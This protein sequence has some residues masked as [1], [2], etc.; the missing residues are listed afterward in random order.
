MSLTR[1]KH[2]LEVITNIVVVLFVVLA[3]VV[4]AKNY[5]TSRN[6][7]TASAKI[8]VGSIFPNIPETNYGQS[9]KTLVIALN[10]YCHYCTQSIP[11]YQR[12]AEAQK[13]NNNSFQAVAVFL[14]KEADLVKQYVEEKKL[15][16]N[17]VPSVDFDKLNITSTP[18]L[19]L[20]DNAGKVLK[21]WVGELSEDREKEVFEEIG[22]PYKPEEVKSTTTTS[23]VKKTIDVFD[24]NKPILTIEPQTKPQDIQKRFVNYFDVDGKGNIYL[25]DVNSLL[26]YDSQGKL[27]NTHSFPQD[28]RTPFCVDDDGNIYFLNQSGL[29]VYSPLLT[30]IKDIPLN[31]IISKDSIVLKIAFDRKRNQIY[32]QVFNESPL[33]QKLYK[34]DLQTQRT[35]EIFN[36]QKPVRFNPT[37]TPGAFD[38]TLGS[39]YLYVSDIYAY[40]IFLFSL[41]DSSLVK[42]FTQPYKASPIKKED[43][44]LPIRKASISGLGENGTLQKYPPIFHL[45]FT[46]NNRL[47]IWTSR[48]DKNNRQVVDVYDQLMNFVGVDLKYAH[49][50]RNNYVFANDKV[51]VPDFGF[52]KE[53]QANSMSPLEV[54]SKPLALKVFAE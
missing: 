28:F 23:E 3:V 1:L 46:S 17:F 38:F 37:Y 44:N 8:K 34:L 27:I 9:P 40:K 24:E 47:L 7:E 35:R 39:Q 21:S 30:K 4:I 43:G 16:V 6:K 25:V 29:S 14:N 26:V 5:L 22:I 36:L 51:Y 11:F 42:T 49:P 31:G 15:S 13:E 48:R 50:G 52:G 12:L 19:V 18:T 54:P 41:S 20:I 53:V 10:V 2:Y 45:N 33:S 32:I